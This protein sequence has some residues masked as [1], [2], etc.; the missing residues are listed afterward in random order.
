VVK[1]KNKF[2]STW[3]N[4][5]EIGLIYGKSA[6]A[7]GKALVELGLKDSSTKNPTVVA[8]SGGIAQSTPLKDGTPFYLWHK[9][10][11]CEKLDALDGWIRQSQEQRDLQKLTSEYI[12]WI[13]QAIRADEKGEHHVIVD[14]LFDEAQSYAK[15]IKKR[16]AD[17]LQQSNELIAKAKLDE[18][19]LIE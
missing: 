12:S 16:G 6:I 10:K 19:Y 9:A 5:K 17:F 14:G 1:S 7:V 13:R 15:Q 11:T 8:L 18:D 2:K 4:Q 3:K